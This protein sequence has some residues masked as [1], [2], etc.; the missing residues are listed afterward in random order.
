[1]RRAWIAVAVVAAALASAPS[2]V[3]GSA[4]PVKPPDCSKDDATIVAKPEGGVV[5]GTVGRRRDFRDRRGG[6]HRGR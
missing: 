6:R 2:W 3:S 4:A 1:M 5:K